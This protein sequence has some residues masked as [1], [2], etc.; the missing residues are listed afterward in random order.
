MVVQRMKLWRSA[1]PKCQV[2]K[3]ETRKK[4]SS[5]PVEIDPLNQKQLTSVV[6]CVKMNVIEC[7]TNDE[8]GLTCLIFH[9]RDFIAGKHEVTGLG[10]ARVMRC[11]MVS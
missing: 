11:K 9:V 3:V 7:L 4:I 1:N 8:I 6:E 5:T 10:N 2:T